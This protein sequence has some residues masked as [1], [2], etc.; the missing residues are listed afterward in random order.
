MAARSI[1]S[2]RGARRAGRARL[3][4]GLGAARA[5]RARLSGGA[6]R[7]RDR[8]GRGMRAGRRDGRHH[9]GGR[10][11][12]D[13]RGGCRARARLKEVAAE[14][15]I[16]SSARRASA[17]S[18][19]GRRVLTA[20]AAFAEPD[21]P[22][23]RIFAASHSGSMIGALM[24][25]GKAQGHRLCGPRLGR[26]RGR[27]VDRRD[28]RGDA[29][30]SRH[31]RLPAVP[32]NH[33]QG[34][35]A[36]RIR[37]GAAAR[38]KPVVAYKLGRSAAARELA[39]SHTGALA[40]EDD[41]ASVF[42]ADCGIARV[43]TL[44]GLIEALA[45]GAPHADPPGR[46]ARPPTVAVV[47]TTAG[48][49]TMVVD[50]LAMRGVAVE[51]PTPET[52]ARLAAHRRRGDAGAHRRSHARRRALR[53]DEG[54]A[55]RA[56]HRAGVRPGAG[57]GR[58]VGA[59]LSRARGQA[60][61]RQRGC[62]KADRGVPGARSARRAGAARRGRRAELP[63][64]GGLRRRDRGGAARA[65]RRSRAVAGAHFAGHAL[66]HGRMLDELEAYALLDRLGVPRA[67]AV[68]L[69]AAIA[70]RR[71]PCPFPIRSRSRRCRPTSRTSPMSAASCSNVQDGDALLAAIKAMRHRAAAHRHHA[72]SRA[73]RADD[74]RP[75]RGADRLPRR[76]R[77]RP[78]GHGGGRRH[79][80]P[81]STA[82][83]ACGSRRSICRPRRR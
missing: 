15:G 69:D 40:G 26:Q 35:S 65:A 66:A 19:C 72:A 27:P 78:A 24:S 54:R 37:A 23:G 55:R 16:R 41:V 38:G 47:T 6:D 81:K 29:R 70:R 83:A 80:T 67:P 21:L 7:G 68:A 73:G 28:L 39:V 75:R 51:P 77:R 58:L 34:G 1:R 12:R 61:H 60:D 53:R 48:G 20:N 13:R 76:P 18:T 79:P 56:D 57:G 5:A 74:R 10:L 3:A 43:E 31:R 22:V 82:T 4:V 62:R 44:E 71:P 45:A 17:W 9:A 32:R 59:L 2:I 63:H 30:R 52:F 64:A 11:F 36:A 46:G 8:R 49:A 50:P 14:T 42:L 25:R 33:A